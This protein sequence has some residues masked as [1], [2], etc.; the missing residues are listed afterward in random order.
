MSGSNERSDG[1]PVFSSG[2]GQLVF[3]TQLTSP[4]A[5]V[6][7]QLQV[8]TKL[9]VELEMIGQNP[10]ICAKFNGQVAGGVASQHSAQIRDCLQQ[11]VRYKAEVT[12]IQGGQIRVRVFPA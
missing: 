10:A 9:A 11:G 7:S 6:T 8:G 5:N 1:I 12:H 3:D 4:K 2:C